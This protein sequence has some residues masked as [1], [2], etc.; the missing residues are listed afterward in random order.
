[1]AVET[2]LVRATRELSQAKRVGLGVGIPATLGLGL[3]SAVLFANGNE[4]AGLITAGGAGAI[5]TGLVTYVGIKA[6]AFR[7][8]VEQG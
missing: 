8:A 6:V 7:R 2:P 1:M 4:T 3:I 5:D